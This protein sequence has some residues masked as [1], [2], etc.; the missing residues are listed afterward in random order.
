MKECVR[1]GS[2]LLAPSGQMVLF[3]S[4]NQFGQW[5]RLF[6]SVQDAGG[7]KRTCLRPH[8]A[9]VHKY[10]RQSRLRNMCE[11]ALHPLRKPLKEEKPHMHVQHKNHGHIHSTFPGYTNVVKNILRLAPG[12]SVRVQTLAST[13][14]GAAD[15]PCHAVSGPGSLR[16][17]QKNV[18]LLRELASLFTAGGTSSWTCSLRP[19]VRQLQLSPSRNTA[20]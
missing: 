20:Y 15:P 2:D 7:R 9:A 17:E 1:A 11:W 18:K 5:Y 14:R 12:D 6:H 19:S 16:P 8:S 10:S 4:A 3:C 13:P